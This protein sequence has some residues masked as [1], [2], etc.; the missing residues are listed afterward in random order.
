MKTVDISGLGGSYE[1]G[2]QKMLINGLKFLNGHP[3][4]DWSAY[5]EYRGVFG[6]TIAEGC[7]AKELDDAVCQ[8]VEP[9]GAMHSAVINHLAYIN[10]HNY[11]GWISEAEKQGMTV[12]LIP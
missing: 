11:D 5:K 6:L 1:A 10:K 2:C 8:D 9:S 7:E 4:F 3:N 12:Y